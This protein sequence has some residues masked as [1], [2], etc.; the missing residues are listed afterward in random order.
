MAAARLP[1]V[2]QLAIR[3]SPLAGKSLVNPNP[4]PVP[5]RGITAEYGSKAARTGVTGEGT[6][7]KGL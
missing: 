5:A 1:L 7:V 6:N 3:L 2:K 4:L